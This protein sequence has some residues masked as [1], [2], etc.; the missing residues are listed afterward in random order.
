[1][2]TPSV[3]FD[4]NGN[5]E[6]TALDTLVKKAPP[7][8]VKDAEPDNYEPLAKFLNECVKCA[9]KAIEKSGVRKGGC[10]YPNLTFFKWGRVMRDRVER[11]EPLKPDVI[12]VDSKD[13]PDECNWSPPEGSESPRVEIPVEVKDNWP[14][15]VPQVGTYALGL[16]MAS[17]LRSNSLVIGFNTKFAVK[18]NPGDSKGTIVGAIRFMLFQHGGISSSEDLDMAATSD[19]R[20][21]VVRILA[22]IM[23]WQTEMDA[24]IPA[25]TNGVT[26]CLPKSPTLPNDLVFFY[27]QRVLCHRLSLRGRN[28]FVARIGPVKPKSV[29][30]RPM[31]QTQRDDKPPLRKKPRIAKSQPATTESTASQGTCEEPLT[32]LI[33]PRQFTNQQVEYTSSTPTI[34]A[35]G[36]TCLDDNSNLVVKCVWS[37]KDRAGIE[38]AMYAACSGEF[39]C[40]AFGCS[41]PA[42]FPDG[43]LVTN[44]PYLPDVDDIES[45]F[46]KVGNAE[47]QPDHVEERSLQ[48]TVL[49][50]EGQSLEAC[51]DS[52]DLVICVGHALLGKPCSLFIDL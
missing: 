24:G 34:F 33:T 9:D 10:L 13:K 7:M 1:M 26:I 40:P 36:V 44:A 28:T 32:A 3:Y 11:S 52:A 19:G 23:L 29:D 42:R 12:G 37:T 41:F 39:G 18:L 31:N 48:V 35:P 46:W 22:R 6:L 47:S 16:T 14:V 20:I 25:F 51:E 2:I 4:A 21:Q 5:S 38:S 43:R 50:E 27:V 8:Q 30:L 17:P 15:L 49:L 45:R